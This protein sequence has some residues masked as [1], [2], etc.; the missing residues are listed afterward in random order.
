MSNSYLHP[1]PCST[2]SLYLSLSLSLALCV[3]HHVRMHWCR[4]RAKIIW[5]QVGDA[6]AQQPSALLFNVST[7]FTLRCTSH[8]V[9]NRR[10]ALLQSKCSRVPQRKQRKGGKGKG[11]GKGRRNYW[12]LQFKIHGSLLNYLSYLI[13]YIKTKTLQFLFIVN[14]IRKF[15]AQKLAITFIS[16]SGLS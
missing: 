16:V 4:S 6:H 3:Y 8:M 15:N 7:N 10:N 14:F 12:P 5:R 1:H 11:Q 2:P 9:H 13:K